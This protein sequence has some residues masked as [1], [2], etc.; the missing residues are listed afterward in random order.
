M[1]IHLQ[2]HSFYTYNRK[3]AVRYAVWLQEQSPTQNKGLRHLYCK[4]DSAESVPSVTFV[5]TECWMSPFLRGRRRHVVVTNLYTW[6][7]DQRGRRSRMPVSV[8]SDVIF[9]IALTSTVPSLN[10]AP[11]TNICVPSSSCTHFSRKRSRRLTQDTCAFD[12]ALAIML[13]GILSSKLHVYS[14]TASECRNGHSPL[15]LKWHP[16]FL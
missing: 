16:H 2:W 7:G 12:G 15:Q 1:C 9:N 4:Q 14:T 5:H 11:L 13:Q 8:T 10:T 3:M 6:I